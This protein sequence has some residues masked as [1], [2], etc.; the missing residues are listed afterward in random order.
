MTEMM[1]SDPLTTAH[2]WVDLSRDVW[3][4]PGLPMTGLLLVTL[5]AKRL[6]GKGE[7]GG[8]R[9]RK[10]KGVSIR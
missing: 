3:F 6:E 9:G 7:G 1:D 8:W 10:E 4:G 2:L 5:V